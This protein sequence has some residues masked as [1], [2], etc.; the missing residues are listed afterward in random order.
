MFPEVPIDENLFESN[1]VMKDYWNRS[2]S[3]RPFEAQDEAPED[4][5]IE[6]RK[7]TDM[8]YQQGTES[9]T[10]ESK[11]APVIDAIVVPKATSSTDR[12]TLLL[13]VILAA[14]VVIWFIWQ[15]P[16]PRV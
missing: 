16:R 10:S 14:L 11:E 3:S 13:L 8:H 4:D 7:L 2:T 12:T 5:L 15:R 1:E 6:L 9:I